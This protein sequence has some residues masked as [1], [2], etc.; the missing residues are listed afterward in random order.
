MRQR[1]IA[2]LA[3]DFVAQVAEFFAVEFNHFARRHANQIVVDL[4][5]CN[6]LVIRLLVVEEDLFKDAGI[7]KMGEGAI[8]GGA[9]DAMGQFFQ[10]RYELVGLEEA[11]LTQGGIEDHGPLGGEFELLLVE[12]AAKDGADR[13]VGED[14]ALG[15]GGK[16]LFLDA[17]KKVG[18]LGH[19]A[20]EV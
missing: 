15:F 2:V 16:L 20:E 1:R 9:G 14:L 19:K 3:T 17:G 10:L 4:S 13:L 12:V 18:A 11:F 8:D 7:L 6:Y 5:A